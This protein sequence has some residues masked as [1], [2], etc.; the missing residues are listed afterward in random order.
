MPTSAQVKNTPTTPSPV[1][2]NNT[3][4]ASFL[5]YHFSVAFPRFASSRPTHIKAVLENFNIL[6]LVKNLFSPYKRM[7][8]SGKV[9]LSEKLSYNIVS[10]LV[11]A[12]A[13]L[14][15]ATAGLFVTVFFIIFDFFAVG[16]Y[17]ILPI[18]SYI[19]YSQVQNNTITAADL[20]TNSSLLAKLS[21][22]QIYLYL[23]TFFDQEFKNLF[24][25]L[26]EASAIG[27][28]AG[29]KSFEPFLS[30]ADSWPQLKTFLDKK[31]IKVADFKL[32]VSY[33]DN[34]LDSK[35]QIKPAPIGQS[36]I[37]GYTNTLERFGT[38]LTSIYHPPFYGKKEM[39]GKIEKVLTRAK[40]NNVLLVGEEGVGKHTILEALA[41]A[42]TRGELLS[43]Q[44]KRLILLD[45]VALLGTTETITDAQ[46]TFENLL[47]E[48]KSAGN[49]I[50]AFDE[51]D[52]ITTNQ[53]GRT[54]LSEVINTL[55]TDNSLPLLGLASVDNFNQFIR[56]NSG[57]T[58][59]FERIDVEEPARD[60]LITILVSKATSVSQKDKLQTSFSAILEIVDQSSR[61][62]ADK[63]QPEKSILIYEDAIA[64]AKRKKLS[65]LDVETVDTIISE[66][67]K[68]PIGKIS[69]NE[70]EK[71]SDLE[72]LLH[73]RI[74]GQSEAIAQ[75]SKAMRRAR[76]QL[77]KT[78]KPMGSFLFLGPT[79]VGKTETSK[80]LAQSYFGNDNKMVRLD[81]TE[82]QGND[83]VARLI[84]NP[85]TKTPGQLT[86]QIR[87]QPYGILL[88]DEFEKASADVQNLFLQ[89][90]DEG[91]LTDAF[92]KKVSFTNI[93]VI[94]TSNAAAEFI[95]EQISAHPRGEVEHTTGKHPGG[96]TNLQKKLVDY[97]LS[98]GLFS[99]E[100]INRFDATVVF[101]PLSQQE[102]VQVAYLML[103]N[104]AAQIKDSKNIT[105]E[106]SPELAQAVA[107][108]GFV[109]AFG[110][111]PIRRL[112]QD[113]IEDE[114]A[115]LII[116]GELQNGSTIGSQKLLQFMNK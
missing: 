29:Q 25:K 90:L 89:I 68:T 19:E 106:I 65:Q 112:I 7:S 38:E 54:D 97:V 49:I 94:A 20:A 86:T 33:L 59:F 56:P 42:I 91:N 96:E 44:D 80:A 55:L 73:K 115:K 57:M 22:T 2:N 88:V 47:K 66:K 37:Y 35:Q 48:A 107:K 28:K 63:K 11:G 85:Q 104:L 69:Q 93:I 3:L 74:V 95:R 114:V 98:K 79:G 21:K 60:E 43:L 52:R 116:S 17:L 64:E 41:G 76:A 113:K 71:L 84:G 110:A 82:F 27:T 105:L 1:E 70:A 9:S 83:A 31:S 40:N 109:Q 102:V 45:I 75:I 108:E 18:F 62:M 103:T 67:S 61:L 81:M 46:S 10:S 30:L 15:L 14:G 111:R 87:E 16:F 13:R 39:L 92:G 100:L 26:P 8:L 77:E 34:L 24:D 36:L 32:L 99:P 12:M 4:P 53:E 101:K 58:S 23:C 78:T 50:L 51:I 6:S 72:T 5:S